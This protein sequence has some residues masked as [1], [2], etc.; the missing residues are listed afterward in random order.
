[1]SKP[2]PSVETPEQIVN[3]WRSMNVKISRYLFQSPVAVAQLC[4]MIDSALRNANNKTCPECVTVASDSSGYCSTCDSFT[5]PSD[6]SLR[7]VRRTKMEDAVRNEREACTKDAEGYL[8]N[9]RNNLSPSSVAAAIRE[10]KG[11]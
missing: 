7:W 3:R 9:Y 6:F 1:M 5:M 4:E 10:G 11:D 2:E 8:S